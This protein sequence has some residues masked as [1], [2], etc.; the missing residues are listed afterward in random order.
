MI[1]PSCLGLEPCPMAWA[2]I[3]GLQFVGCNLWAAT[4]LLGS[5]LLACWRCEL[6]KGCALTA[7]RAGPVAPLHASNQAERCGLPIF[8]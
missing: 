4:T 6:G 8:P 5:R 3:F 7:W 2:A 1:V